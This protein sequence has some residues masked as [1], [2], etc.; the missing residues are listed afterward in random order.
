MTVNFFENRIPQELIVRNH[1]LCWRFEPR[2]GKLTKA[3][4]NP[5]TGNR[6]SVRDSITWGSFDEAKRARQWF[7]CDGVGFVLSGDGV[8]ALDLDGCVRWDGGNHVIEP[9][10]EAVITAVNS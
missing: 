7:A 8:V 6:A 9:S 3:P 5:H 1:W 4:I 2:N 10:A